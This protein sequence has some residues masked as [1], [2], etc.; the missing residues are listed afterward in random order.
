[1]KQGGTSG[2]I[3]NAANEIVVTAFL[4]QGL[5]FGSMITIVSE[6]LDKIEIVQDA[7]IGA[8]IEADE[9]ARSLAT[10]LVAKVTV[11]T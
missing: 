7:V 5:P 11:H 4:E 2:A 1:M 8:V 6:T 9:E 10:Q 3:L